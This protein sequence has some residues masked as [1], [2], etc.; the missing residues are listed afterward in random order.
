MLP[1]LD[2][3]I[4]CLVTDRRLLPT[5]PGGGLASV[6][7]LVALAGAAAAAGIHVMQLRERDLSGGDLERLVQRCVAATRGAPTRI[8]VNDRL[9]VAIAAGADGVHLRGDSFEPARART[10]APPGFLIGRSVR[11]AQEA[12][13]VSAGGGAD[14]LIFGAVFETPSKPPAVPLA[15]PDGLACVVEAAGVPVLAIGG[16]SAETMP[17]LART[18]V[19]GFAAIRLFLGESG[20]LLDGPGLR[21]TVQRAR[22]LFDTGKRVV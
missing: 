4:V 14:F 22:R 16:V 5:G 3:P 10:L 12:A 7:G 8:L 9:D 15:G 2:R 21:D 1:W 11:S 6:D 13:S 18:G 20:A 19:A 17:T